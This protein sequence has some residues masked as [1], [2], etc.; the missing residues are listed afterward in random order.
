GAHEEPGAVP[1]RLA[2]GRHYRQRRDHRRRPV[3]DRRRAT[4][5]AADRRDRISYRG[6][7]DD[8]PVQG[9]GAGRV[10]H[11]RGD[12]PGPVADPRQLGGAAGRRRRRRRGQ[13]GGHLSAAARGAGAARRRGRNRP[14]DGQS[15]RDH[16]DRARH[17]GTG[18]ADPG[19]DRQ[20]L[21]DGDRDR[22]DD[23]AAAGAAGQR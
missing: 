18:A 19:I 9:V 11:H 13:G 8:R 21:A 14:A 22:A 7:G 20:F 2:A 6:R 12:E 3:A 15:V 4:G 16:A 1:R 23:H 10:P 5:R 17:R